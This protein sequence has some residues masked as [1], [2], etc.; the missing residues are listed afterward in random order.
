MSGFRRAVKIIVGLWVISFLAA[1][2]YAHFTR[3]NYVNRGGR[4]LEQS[5]FCA[6]LDQNIKPEVSTPKCL[7]LLHL[8]LA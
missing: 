7:I 6:L 5:A 8:P 1:V 4:R 3:V 2:P